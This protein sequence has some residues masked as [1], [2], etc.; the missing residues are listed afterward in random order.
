MDEFEQY[1]HSAT[2]SLRSRPSVLQWW[3]ENKTRYPQ[4]SCWAFDLHSIPAMF[5]ECEWVFLSAGQLFTK[6][7]NRL[8]DDIGEAKKYLLAWRRAEIFQLVRLPT[9]GAR[10]LWSLEFGVGVFMNFCLYIWSGCATA[11]R[12]AE[13]TAGRTTRTSFGRSTGW[14]TGEKHAEE[15]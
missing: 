14:L 4:L 10:V 11:E 3:I 6:Q 12:T 13:C 7:R 15:L 5:A 9:I 8:L 2:T 1:C